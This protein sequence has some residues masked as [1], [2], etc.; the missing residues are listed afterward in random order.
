MFLFLADTGRTERGRLYTLST[1][2]VP[3]FPSPH[4]FFLTGSL[5]H[6][7]SW[8]SK[9]KPRQT[10]LPKSYRAPPLMFPTTTVPSTIVSGVVWQERTDGGSAGSR[11]HVPFST[12]HVSQS[13]LDVWQRIYARY[14][15]ARIICS[16]FAT[17]GSILWSSSSLLPGY[18]TSTNGHM[19]SRLHVRHD[20]L[21]SLSA[22]TEYLS[23]LFPRYCLTR[24]DV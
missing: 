12:L 1:L 5:N 15:R 22:F 19:G 11:V 8:P 18:P 9:V 3:L 24:K 7:P 4:P 16:R 2:A 20:P 13:S 10:V 21:S 23:S 6:L 17:Q 14:M